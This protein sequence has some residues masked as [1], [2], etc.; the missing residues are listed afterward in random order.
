MKFSEIS[1]NI[2]KNNLLVYLFLAIGGM[3]IFLSKFV[4]FFSFAASV[5][6]IFFGVVFTDYL[7]RHVVVRRQRICTF[8]S[9]CLIVFLLTI[10]ILKY[11]IFVERSVALRHLWYLYYIPLVCIPLFLFYSALFMGE[12]KAQ[13]KSLIIT[14]TSIIS[15]LLLGMVCTNDLHQLAFKFND[16]SNW[17]NYERSYLFYA[18]FIWILI[19]FFSS[20]IILIRNCEILMGRKYSWLVIFYGS[21]GWG[22]TALL[23][24]TDFQNKLFGENMWE[25]GELYSAQSIMFI[26]TCVRLWL[27]PADEDY[28]RLNDAIA[29]VNEQLQE[30]SEL[31]RLQNELKKEKLE[32]ENKNR[33]YDEIAEN[34]SHES[35]QILKL[36]QQ[37]NTL[38]VVCVYGAYIKRLANLR[39][40]ASEQE[41]IPMGEL[42]LSIREIAKYISRTKVFISLHGNSDGEI[43]ALDAAD[44]LGVLNYII[45]ENLAEVKGISVTF[46]ENKSA[47]LRVAVEGTITSDILTD[48]G[49]SIVCSTVAEDDITY[50]TFGFENGGDAV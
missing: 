40:M 10:R 31:S 18:I 39:L 47:F 12:Q 22:M 24:L 32:I 7:R 14:V 34:V 27:I 4:P 8:T 20:Y 16:I 35:A 48:I 50:I 45:C 21:F 28:N 46:S 36:T 38:P 33:L 42:V 13:K 44:I 15:I 26:L 11:K 29:E 23:I 6:F 3:L 41:Y 19:L 25:F 37:S 17:D 1:R 30:E 49:D 5:Y 43:R 9:A 2:F